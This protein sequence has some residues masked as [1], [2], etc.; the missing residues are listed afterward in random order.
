MADALQTT[1]TQRSDMDI[2]EDIAALVRDYPPLTQSRHWFTVTVREGEVTL[3][4]NIKSSIAYRVLHDN[5]LNMPGV[6]AIHTDDIHYD[7]S[8]RLAVGKVLPPGVWA[9]VDFGRVAV[10]G[11]LPP[12][13]KPDALL[14]KIAG[15]PGVRR[16]DNLLT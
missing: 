13:R 8:I 3:S 10:M 16:V 2:A 12:R 7:E 5:L 6:V 11:S 14:K 9:R 1:V 4:G 15:I